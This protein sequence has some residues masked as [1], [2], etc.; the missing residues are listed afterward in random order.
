MRRATGPVSA[1][2][3]PERAAIAHVSACFRAG[4]LCGRGPH[5]G[6][7]RAYGLATCAGVEKLYT[8][9]LFEKVGTEGATDAG[10]QPALCHGHGGFGGAGVELRDHSGQGSPDDAIRITLVTGVRM[11]LE[12]LAVPLRRFRKRFPD[13]QLS[14]RHGNNRVAEELILADEADLALT[15]EAGFGQQSQHIH[16]EPAYSVEFLAVSWKKHP[17][18]ATS[19]TSLRE[20][21]KH[22]LIVT[23][24]GTHGRD[25]LDQALHR[26][27][28]TARIAAETDNSGFTIACVQAGMGLG[29]VAG[30]PEGQLSRRLAVR[31]L[32]R[33]LGQRQIV[34]MWR[35]GRR[36]TEP[37]QELVAERCVVRMRV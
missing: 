7:V 24:P 30:R 6:V 35:K 10:G 17:F 36:L 25:A 4:R 26:E 1:V 37:L 13:N 23:I 3:R 16:Y 22:D 29:I 21:V 8:V 34:C 14:I 20:L 9:R 32:R 19:R 5:L 27:R 31:S 11:M 18:F 28:L 15:L 2:Q 33:L 12:D